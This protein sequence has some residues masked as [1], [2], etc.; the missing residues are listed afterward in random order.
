MDDALLDRPLEAAVAELHARRIGA[1]ELTDA[2]LAR[3]ARREPEL[4]AFIAVT[5]DAAR[6]RAR[7]IDVARP[8]T[9]DEVVAVV[10]AARERGLT[11]KAVGPSIANNVAQFSLLHAIGEPLQRYDGIRPLDLGGLGWRR[12]L[13]HARTHIATRH[14][15]DQA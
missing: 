1:L 10:L 7:A 2:A 8:T 11:V 9:V 15:R 5:A 3:I 12:G 13:L 4:N 6:E 14:D